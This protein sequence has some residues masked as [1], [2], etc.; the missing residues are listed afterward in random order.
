[1][2]A[3]LPNGLPGPLLAIGKKR[4]LSLWPKEFEEGFMNQFWFRFNLR[5][6]VAGEQFERNTYSFEFSV[7]CVPVGKLR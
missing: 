5:E 1:M 3:F 7:S 2:S 4:H 6:S